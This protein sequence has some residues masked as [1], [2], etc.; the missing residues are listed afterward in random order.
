MKKTYVPLP[1]G[2]A[3]GRGIPALKGDAAAF[4]DAVRV[5]LA[6]HTLLFVSGKIGMGPEGLADRNMREQARQTLKNIQAT[7]E[8]QGGDMSDVVRFRIYVSAIDAASIRDVHDARKEFYAEGQYPASTLV[9]VDQFVRDGALIEIEADV[10][11]P[12]KS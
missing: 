6:D 5:D 7:V 3:P 1:G 2:G 11:I 10:V 12:L 9:R 4:S 8:G